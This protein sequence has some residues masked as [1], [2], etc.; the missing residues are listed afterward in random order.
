MNATNMVVYAATPHADGTKTIS[1]RR[2][3]VVKMNETLRGR[4]S[5]IIKWDDKNEADKQPWLASNLS[6]GQR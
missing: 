6:F 1:E 2:G 4:A 5:Y 3:R